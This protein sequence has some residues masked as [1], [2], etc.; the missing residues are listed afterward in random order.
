M[1]PISN[2]WLTPLK[3]EFSKPYYKK[4]YQTVN[5]EYRTHLI[6]PPADDIFNAFAFTPLSEV[7]A[8]ILGQDPYHGDGQAHGLCFSVKPD[9]EI[10]PSLV[11]I[12]KELQDDCGC[13]IPNNGYLTKWAKQG[14]LLLN[15]VLTVRAH[16]ANSHRGIGWEEFTDAAIRI[17][18]DQ[19]RPIVFILWGR[20]AQMKKAM[21][22][23]P[24]HLILEAPHPSPLSAYRGF[25]G[26]RPF[27]R[28]NKFLQQHG[29]EPIDWQI[30]N[31]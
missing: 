14:V 24:K 19:D 25:F 12:Y 3:P 23:N 30:E 11:N 9:V 26:S 28:T 22:N 29:I 15:T 31:V 10:P 13:Y 8:V 21:L 16:Q 5:E 1:P 2:D 27:S 7:K 4:L 20:P 17:L 6:F 18:N